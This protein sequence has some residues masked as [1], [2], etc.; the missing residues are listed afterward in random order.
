MLTC[1]EASESQC[2]RR[3]EF[4]RVCWMLQTGMWT[5]CD[6][7]ARIEGRVLTTTLLGTTLTQVLRRGSNQMTRF[8]MAG[9]WELAD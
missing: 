2:R 9:L 3:H 5:L 6:D 4:E 8:R 1:N 7:P